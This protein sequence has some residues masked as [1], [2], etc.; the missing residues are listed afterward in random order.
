MIT[1]LA[2]KSTAANVFLF[3]ATDCSVIGYNIT[4][5][6]KEQKVTIKLIT[7]IIFYFIPC[8]LVAFGQYWLC[9][10]LQYSSRVYARESFYGGEK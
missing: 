7:K 1:G 10:K 9:Q 5:K 8:F 3:V 4:H 2:F 6:D